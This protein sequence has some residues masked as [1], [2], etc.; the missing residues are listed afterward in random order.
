MIYEQ[1]DHLLAR[2][3]HRVAFLPP[4]DPNSE[5]EQGEWV[6][7]EGFPTSATASSMTVHGSPPYDRDSAYEDALRDLLGVTPIADEMA[8]AL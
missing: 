7:V 6:W 8:G 4:G 1:L 5:S 2:F 3:N